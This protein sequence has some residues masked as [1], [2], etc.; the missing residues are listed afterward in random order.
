MLA[1]WNLNFPGQIPTQSPN[2]GWGLHIDFR[3]NTAYQIASTQG[4]LF[5][6]TEA[7][8]IAWPCLYC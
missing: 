1:R 5:C 7:G 4:G 6:C 3:C 2:T 8:G